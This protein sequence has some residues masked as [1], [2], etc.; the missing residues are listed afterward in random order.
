M[1]DFKGFGDL[2]KIAKREQKQERKRQARRMQL[3]LALTSAC[4]FG[5]ADAAS[6][7]LEGKD[8]DGKRTMLWA[9]FGFLYYG[10]VVYRLYAYYDLLFG[11]SFIK[12]AAVDCFVHLPVGVVPAFYGWK[13]VGDN[14]GN[15]PLAMEQFNREVREDYSTT[16]ATSSVCWFP[17]QCFCFWGINPTY[18][19][20]WVSGWSFLHKT[21]MLK[22]SYRDPTAPL[23]NPMI[24]DS[25]DREHEILREEQPIPAPVV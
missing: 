19:L 2:A 20:V 18:R 23:F 21:G 1:A 25:D 5:S 24:T 3:R 6:Q 10:G 11:S 7:Y 9:S 13:S 12:K 16:T 4:I 8:Y 17:V 14:N 22:F 15:I